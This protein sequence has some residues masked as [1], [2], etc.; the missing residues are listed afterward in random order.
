MPALAPDHKRL[1]PNRTSQ[2]QLWAHLDHRRCTSYSKSLSLQKATGSGSRP[3]SAR[4]GNHRPRRMADAGIDQG[5][6]VLCRWYSRLQTAAEHS[7]VSPDSESQR[8]C[9]GLE[10]SEPGSRAHGPCTAN[11]AALRLAAN[12]NGASWNLG[13]FTPA[14]PEMQPLSEQGN[15][16]NNTS[17]CHKGVRDQVQHNV[18]TVF[19]LFVLSK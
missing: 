10:A 16:F 17:L 19:V 9:A 1:D 11:L 6:A 2:Q 12:C 7:T 15:K 8:L 18:H 5:L 13:I 14:P 4:H 3:S